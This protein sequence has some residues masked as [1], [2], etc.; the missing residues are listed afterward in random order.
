MIQRDSFEARQR[1]MDNY[2]W[3]SYA[4]WPLFWC[5]YCRENELDNGGWRKSSTS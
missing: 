2:G 3:F 4:F 1:Q 5:G